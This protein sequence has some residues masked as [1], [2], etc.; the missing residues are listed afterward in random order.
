MEIGI[1]RRVGIEVE[2]RTYSIKGRIRNKIVL[3]ETPLK[4]IDRDLN[5]SYLQLVSEGDSTGTS[6]F[7]LV[8]GA[9][10][11]SNLYQVRDIIKIAKDISNCNNVTDWVN[12]FNDVIRR[13]T[14]QCELLNFVLD[15]Q[16]GSNSINI[17]KTGF[18]TISIQANILIPVDSFADR[19]KVKEIFSGMSKNTFPFI[20]V[21]E[22]ID[23]YKLAKVIKGAI[24][25]AVYVCSIYSLYRLKFNDN[26]TK[27][28]F[29]ILFK[30]ELTALLKEL[31][32]VTIIDELNAKGGL[33]D[34]IIS[35]FFW[36]TNSIIFQENMRILAENI[37]HDP[38]CFQITPRS[39]GVLPM[40]RSGEKVCIVMELRKGKYPLLN[41]ISEFLDSRILLKPVKPQITK[42]VISRTRQV[43]RQPVRPIVTRTVNISELSILWK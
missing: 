5:I 34:E 24:F 30:V 7:E 39:E 2:L 28:H 6:Y 10:E 14:S 35:R 18:N 29:P 1:Y 40:Y 41:K 3:A 36:G 23:K 27:Q 42:P 13:R 22:S 19:D 26:I 16:A 25:I 43:V 4:I 37:R 21:F 20:T 38:P 11:Y 9:V 12:Q 32:P 31:V 8:F 17:N 15:L 33:S